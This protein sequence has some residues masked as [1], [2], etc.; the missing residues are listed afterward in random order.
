MKKILQLATLTT[1][2][3][4]ASAA[5]SAVLYSNDFE[6]QAGD[7]TIAG[8][9]I[10][11][12]HDGGAWWANAAAGNAE[13][14]GQNGYS[15]VVTNEGGPNQG[16]AQLK[17]YSDYNGW[18]PH[19][20][21]SQNVLTKTYSILGAVD[22][23][24]LGQTVTFSFDAKLGNITDTPTSSSTA[25]I[26][27]IKTS[28][29]SYSDVSGATPVTNSDIATDWATYSTSFLVDAGMIGEE[30][31]IGFSNQTTE[32]WGATGM[33]YDNLSVTSVPVPAA[34]WLMGSA[35]LG[36]AGMKRARK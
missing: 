26:S 1:A 13:F 28:D 8:F 2:I 7:A 27:V 15:S 33:V 9:V 12:Q 4:T 21:G 23:S 17:T 6:G 29:G 30:L 31:Q 11:N 19:N 3:I 36:L 10:G 25:F 34:A 20:N 32:Q 5:Q 22:A 35:L 18:G 14:L 24:L 16:S